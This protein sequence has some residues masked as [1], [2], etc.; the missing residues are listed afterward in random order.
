MPTR[1][2]GCARSFWCVAGNGS[3][4][5][6]TM[7]GHRRLD[8]VVGGMPSRRL[9]C[10]PPGHATWTRSRVRRGCSRPA[11]PTPPT[12]AWLRSRLRHSN[13]CQGRRCLSLLGRGHGRGTASCTAKCG[14]RCISDCLFEFVGMIR[15][16]VPCHDHW[17]RAFCPP[18]LPLLAAEPDTSMQV[19]ARVTGSTSLQLSRTSASASLTRT[20]PEPSLSAEYRPLAGGRRARSCRR[21][22]NII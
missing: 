18:A 20:R 2:L 21:S 8:T 22:T 10:I 17:N 9:D 11:T 16:H 1:R 3:R 12:Q 7:T 5:A 14:I 4:V 15:P 19:A 13:W 6:R